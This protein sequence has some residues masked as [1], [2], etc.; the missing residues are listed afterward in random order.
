MLAKFEPDRTK[1][2]LKMTETIR[3]VI[4]DPFHRKRVNAIEEAANKRIHFRDEMWDGVTRDSRKRLLR[5]EKTDGE[6]WMSFRDFW[7]EFEE[8]SLAS[9]GPDFDQDGQVDRVGMVCFQ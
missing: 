8:I 4:N 2:Q 3:G 1:T 6:F 9:R 5:D 7:E